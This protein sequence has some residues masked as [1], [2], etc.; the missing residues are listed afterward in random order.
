MLNIHFERR[1]RT[2]KDDM[3]KTIFS[4][5]CKKS[6][7]VINV[8]LMESNKIKMPKYSNHRK[9]LFWSLK[10]LHLKWFMTWK[11]RSLLPSKFTFVPSENYN[12]KV[13]NYPV[14]KNAWLSVLFELLY[15]WYSSGGC[16]GSVVAILCT[17]VN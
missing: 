6:C 7:K 11:P 12:T 9:L 3:K 5:K 17:I 10:W 2:W 1:N 14:L 15:E 13:I 16:R 4:M 8:S